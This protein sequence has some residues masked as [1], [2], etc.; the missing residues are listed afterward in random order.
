M[1]PVRKRC[2]TRY[3]LEVMPADEVEVEFVPDHRVQ[4]LA[5]LDGP[6]IEEI[7]S[8]KLRVCDTPGGT[9]DM[10]LHS[11]LAAASRVDALGPK[12]IVIEDSDAE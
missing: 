9:E 1:V 8:Q 5:D 6:L 7:L 2:R 11:A 12:E 4:R 10:D 3:R